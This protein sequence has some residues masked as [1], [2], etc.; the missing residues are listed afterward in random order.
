MATLREIRRRITGVRST[1]KIT[2]AMKMVSASKMRRAQEAIL[3][4]RPYVE[5]LDIMLSNLI[6][7][8]G[9]DYTHDYIEK[10]KHIKSIAII[11]I[12]SH[13]G[14]CGSFNTN[15]F[16]NVKNYI[17]FELKKE[18]PDAKISLITTGKK[19]VAFFKKD[20][21]PKINEFPEIFANLQFSEAKEIVDIVKEKF[22][23]GEIDKIF[24]YY[25]EF[26]NV[27]RQ[28]PKVITLLPIE[29]KEAKEMK[30]ERK[31]FNIDY[32]FEP[33]KEAILDE[34]LPKLIEI[35]LW[36]SLLESNAAEQAARMMAMDNATTNANELIRYLELV[37]N[38]KRQE[39][40]TK[41]M[42]EIVGGAEGLK[43]G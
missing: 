7:A 37:F 23:S 25:N 34:L 43:K 20:K 41:E 27:I 33:G 14:L 36:R 24:V 17:D 22:I 4:A 29:Q 26:I 10:R 6:A 13:R 9:E 40:I 5:K 39:A 12:G 11:V 42:L 2:Q 15:L 28:L 31:S 21:N 16:R 1:A 38:K 18:Y 3:S 30:T 32:I 19:A 8:V 35:K